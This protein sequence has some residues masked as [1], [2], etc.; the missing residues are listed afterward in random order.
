MAR[1]LTVTQILAGSIPVRYPGEWQNWQPHSALNREITV[2]SS[3][4][5]PTVSVAQLGC[6]C[7]GLR[8][9]LVLRFPVRSLRRCGSMN[10]KQQIAWAAGLLEGEGSF[11]LK[12]G[13]C[14]PNVSCHMTDLD[15]LERL[16][17]IFG[18]HI[19]LTTRQKPHHKESWVWTISKAE[20]AVR[21]MELVK[22]FL[23]TRRAERVHH[24]LEQRRK[25]VAAQAQKRAKIHKMRDL[26]KEKYKA[27]GVT[28]QQLAD[29]FGVSRPYVSHILRGKY[30]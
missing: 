5:S 25:F 16:Q 6:G 26:T 1:D 20:D 4:T 29:Q 9:V 12:T 14:R 21:C 3:P 7:G 30:D 28:H 17:N 13:S 24:C 10:K 8:A 18:G 15:V 19:C 2:G 11:L 22:P 23:L 27:G